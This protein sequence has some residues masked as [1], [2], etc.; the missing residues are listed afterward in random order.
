MKKVSAVILAAGLSSRMGQPKF[1]LKLPNGKTFLEEIVEKFH[2]F[3]CAEIIVV[4]NKDGIS[5]LNTSQILL[6]D[7]TKIV[8]NPHP[9]KERFYSLQCGLKALKKDNPV[10]V[11]NV[12]N[13]FVDHKVLADLYS[14]LKGYDYVKPVFEGKGGHPVLFSR[15]LVNDINS[16]PLV[17][18]KLNEYLQNKMSAIVEINEPSILTNINTIEDLD[19]FL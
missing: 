10:F 11:H 17:A 12:D 6:P 8:E 3:G 14:N 19:K 15:K 9:E 4:L 7:N 13:P 1:L 5:A 2:K 16:E 18:I